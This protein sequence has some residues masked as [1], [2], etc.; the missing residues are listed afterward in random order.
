VF[1]EANVYGCREV[2]HCV[3]DDSYCY[4]SDGITADWAVIRLD[5]AVTG[6]T[7]V[8][9]SPSVAN[10]GHN[11]YIVGHPAGLP[12]KCALRLVQPPLPCPSRQ[13]PQITRHK[14]AL[15]PPCCSPAGARHPWQ[16]GICARS[17]PRSVPPAGHR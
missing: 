4:G 14:N 6:R 10:V 1:P 15:T 17:A 12:R 13:A 16:P 3:V 5:R 7:P 11:V 8:T 9:I 2:V